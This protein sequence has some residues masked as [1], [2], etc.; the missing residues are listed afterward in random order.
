MPDEGNELDELLGKMPAIAKAVADF[1]EAVQQSAFDALMAAATGR[2]SPSAAPTPAQS[3]SKTRSRRANTAGKK[4]ASTTEKVG[5]K[6]RR[7]A[8]SQPKVVKEL[9]LRPKGKTSFRDFVAAKNPMNNHDKHAVVIYYLSNE[10]GLP[11]VTS[12]HVFTAWREM[13]W[14][15]PPDFNQSL[16]LTASKKRYLDTSNSEDLRLL[17]TGV[18]RVEHDLPIQLKSSSRAASK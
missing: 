9:D 1:P 6:S 5:A 7:V 18:N 11:N 2:T 12:D 14:R 4:K 15:L 16:R 10:A 8:A 17:S 13:N 3:R